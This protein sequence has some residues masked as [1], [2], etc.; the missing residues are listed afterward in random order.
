MTTDNGYC[1]TKK[2]KPSRSTIVRL[3]LAAVMISSAATALLLTSGCGFQLRGSPSL[4]GDSTDSKSQALSTPIRLSYPLEHR[5]WASRLKTQLRSVGIEVIDAPTE[6]NIAINDGLAKTEQQQANS[7][8]ANSAQA[9]DSELPTLTILNSN[10]S[11]R[12]A[13]YTSRAK[14]AEYTLK[15]Q[16]IYE[17]TSATGEIV[18][19]HLTLSSDR[20]YEFNVNNI[21]GK[22]QEADLIIEELKQDISHK[23]LRHLLKIAP[24]LNPQSLEPAP[25][26]ISTLEN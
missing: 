7:F 26:S 16:L 14:A 13:S 4:Y 11:R 17:V 1:H 8:D 23:L 5:A 22:D 3:T 2:R 19:S 9:L 15:E 12:I 20:V 21:S 24:M 18:V 6:T 25:V 10:S